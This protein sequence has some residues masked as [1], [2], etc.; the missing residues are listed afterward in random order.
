MYAQLF[1]LCKDNWGQLVLQCRVHP[2][3]IAELSG[4]IGNKYWPDSVRID[5]NFK[6][7]KALEWSGLPNDLTNLIVCGK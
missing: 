2:D 6:D 7:L 1:P 5:P 4:T 3:S